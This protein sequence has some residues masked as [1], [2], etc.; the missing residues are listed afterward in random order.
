[1]PRKPRLHVPG[2]LYHVILRGNNRQAIFFEDDDRR[3]W[4]SLIELGLDKYSHRIHAYCWMSNHVHMAV[5]C[6]ER[7][8]SDFVRFIASQYSRATNKKLDRTG[9]LFERRHRAILVQTD[10][11][12]KELVRYIHLNPL[13]AG[14]VDAIDDYPWCG[15]QAY[16]DG[17]PPPW[18]TV[19]WVLSA[20]AES[21]C[22]A[23]RQYARFLQTDC[24]TSIL[25]KLSGGSDEDHRVLGDD[26]FIASLEQEAKPQKVQQTL[27]ELARTICGKHDVSVGELKSPSRERLYAAIRSEI[28]LVA[29]DGEVASTADVAR[30]FRRSQSGMSRAIGLLRQKSKQVNK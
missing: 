5:Q 1:M 16:L 12:L 28:G 18:L 24:P 22:D 8:I 17:N 19:N 21:L 10:S 23:R 30:F 15:H 7:P 26:G 6:H 20:F 4:E 2:G 9:H 3:R 29:V 14:I 27:A 25:E 11:Y 13:R